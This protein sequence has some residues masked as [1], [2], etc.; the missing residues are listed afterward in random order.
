MLASR[1]YIRGVVIG[2]GVLSGFGVFWALA[3]FASL[4]TVVSIIVAVVTAAVL[5]AFVV[6]N[7]R[8]WRLAARLPAHGSPEEADYWRKSG[9]R[10]GIVFGIEFALIAIASGILSS[11]GHE[12]LIPP[13]IALIV[14]IHFLPLSP[15]FRIPTYFVTGIAMSVLAVVCILGVFSGQQLGAATLFIWSSVVGLGSALILWGSASYV[16]RNAYAVANGAAR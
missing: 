1:F 16:L 5:V 10:F 3:S 8:L 12:T 13:V 7:I 15:L 6:A 2:A 14:G 4:P 9:V 11:I